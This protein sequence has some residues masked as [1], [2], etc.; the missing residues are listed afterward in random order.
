MIPCLEGFFVAY[1]TT[2]LQRLR[3]HSIKRKDDK[4]TINSKGFRRKRAWQNFKVLPRHSS[5]GTEENHEKPVRM[6]GL[7]AEI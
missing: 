7:Q 5:G 1:L 6:A 3:L 4:G 2:L